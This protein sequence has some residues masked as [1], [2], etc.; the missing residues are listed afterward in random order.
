MRQNLYPRVNWFGHCRRAES[1][2][3]WQREAAECLLCHL[4]SVGLTRIPEG[5][6][7]CSTRHCHT[8]QTSAQSCSKPAHNRS[9]KKPETHIHTLDTQSLSKQHSSL[10]PGTVIQ[11]KTWV[12]VH[13]FTHIS[14]LYTFFPLSV[15]E[16]L[17]QKHQSSTLRYNLKV[18]Y[19]HI[20]IDLLIQ[21]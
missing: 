19:V 18:H 5:T 12:S 3:S 17:L 16:A 6:C 2:H 21:N 1:L 10:I 15:C 7:V 14:L 8:G 13:S 20:S 4:L 9:A 11:N